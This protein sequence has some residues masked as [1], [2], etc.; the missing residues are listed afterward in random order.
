ML[1]NDSDRHQD[2]QGSQ[3]QMLEKDNYCSGRIHVQQPGAEG[4]NPNQDNGRK[5]Q[6]RWRYIRHFLRKGN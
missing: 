5:Q 6:R 2:V 3:K 1:E 4:K